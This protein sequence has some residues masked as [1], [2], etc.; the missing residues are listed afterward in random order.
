MAATVTYDVA[1]LTELTRKWISWDPNPKTRALAERLLAD[2]N[3]KELQKRMAN[4][5]AFGTA[6]LRGEMTLGFSCMNELT[7]QQASQGLCLALLQLLPEL[8]RTNGV[9]VGYDGRHNSK[10]YADITA[11][12]F[13]SKGVPVHLFSH[14]VPTPFVPFGVNCLKAAAGVMVTASHNPK[15]DNGYKVYWNT[16][17]QIVSP[18]DGVIAKLIDENL[19]P[20]DISNVNKALITDPLEEVSRKYFTTIGSTMCYHRAENATSTL[21]ITYTAMH[22]VGGVYMGRAFESFNLKPYIPVTEQIDP[23][24]EFPTVAFPNPEEGKG[25]LQLSM[26][27]ADSENSPLILATDPDADRLA[28]AEKM[29][30]G[31]W[32]IFNGNEIGSLL[33]HWVWTKFH[34][35]NPTVPPEECLVLNTAVSSRLLPTIAKIEGLTYHETLTGFKWLGT[36]AHDLIQKGKKFLFAYEEAIGFLIGDMSLDKDGVRAAAAFAEMAN[37]LH[38]KGMTCLQQLDLL[39]QRYG[40]FSSCNR[41]FFCYD[42]KLM[43]T[44]FNRIRGGTPNSTTFPASIGGFRVVNVR[45]LTVGYDTTKPGNVPVLPVSRGTQMITFYFEN[46]CLATLRGSGTEPKLK[47]YIELGGPYAEKAR[48]DADLKAIVSAVIAECLE[49]VKNGLTPPSD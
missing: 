34:E 18:I 49:P 17:C 33:G 39:H 40:Y 9:V 29:P 23:D 31:N 7:V 16:G 38:A 30:N 41:Y 28:V 26:N 22:G 43:E 42:P 25:A 1:R 48:I 19:V 2:E 10:T 12:V 32:K 45:D 8:T 21:K 4:R 44:I 3:W 14:L 27:K 46:G 37:C 47:Y 11:A 24:P 13:S 20:W 35:T 15:Q 6:G 36:A 5:I